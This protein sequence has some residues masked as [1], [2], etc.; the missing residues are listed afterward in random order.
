MKYCAT[1][2]NIYKT[3][4]RA[5]IKC[6]QKKCMISMSR[7]IAKGVGKVTFGQFPL[8]DE[9]FRRIATDIV[10]HITSMSQSKNRHLRVMVDYATCYSVYVSL[11]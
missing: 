7:T 11:P 4:T 8:I 1:N 10:G 2:L 6:Q 5:I 9:T 3:E